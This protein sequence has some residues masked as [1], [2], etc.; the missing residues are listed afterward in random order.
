[1]SQFQLTAVNFFT[2][3]NHLINQFLEIFTGNLLILFRK[4]TGFEKQRKE[5]YQKYCTSLTHG[6]K[7]HFTLIQEDDLIYF[8]KLQIIH[9]DSAV[10]LSFVMH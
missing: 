10:G 7:L 8:V 2:M 1:M 5:S 3:A 6:L 9:G 4:R